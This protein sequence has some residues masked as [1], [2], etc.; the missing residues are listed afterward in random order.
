[1]GRWNCR[2]GITGS[3]LKRLRMFF[4]TIEYTA[5]HSSEYEQ[6]LTVMRAGQD[7]F[8]DVSIPLRLM[9]PDLWYHLH[10]HNGPTR[11]VLFQPF[12]V[13]VQS[14][15]RNLFPQ[16]LPDPLKVEALTLLVSGGFRAKRDSSRRSRTRSGS[17]KDLRPSIRARPMCSGPPVSGRKLH[18]AVQSWRGGRGIAFA[19]GHRRV[20]RVELGI[21]CLVLHRVRSDVG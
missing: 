13:Q 2:A 12:P 16:N 11:L 4:L 17:R 18:S 6:K 20:G 3:I 1:V 7:V 21:R 14:A 10:N 15:R 5:E 19:S 9:F 8:E